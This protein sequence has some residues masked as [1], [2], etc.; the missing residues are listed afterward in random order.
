MILAVLVVEPGEDKIGKLVESDEHERVVRQVEAVE[1]HLSRLADVLVHPEAEAEELGQ[2]EARGG[3]FLPHG[4]LG[5]IH[6]DK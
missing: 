6:D 5:V 2:G 1:V 4:H 3:E